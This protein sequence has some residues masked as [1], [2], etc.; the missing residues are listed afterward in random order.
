[1]NGNI[2][3][4]IELNTKASKISSSLLYTTENELIKKY[5]TVLAKRKIELSKINSMN[6]E[7]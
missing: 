5:S 4:A 7:D 6:Y 3:E 2:D 1:M